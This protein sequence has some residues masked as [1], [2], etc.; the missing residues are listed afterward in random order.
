MGY[1][2]VALTGGMQMALSTEDMLAIQQ[3]YARYNHA[4][5]FARPAEWAACFT[6]DGVFSSA[7]TGES[8]GTEAL[9]AFATGFAARLKA[10]HWITNLLLEGDGD[11]ATGTCYLQLW[12]VAAAPASLLTTGTYVDQLAK[13]DGA[14]KFTR[15]EVKA[16]N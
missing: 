3:L 9:V 16:D 12:N 2:A 10:R 15:R 4:I 7:T 8:Q 13:M 6:A 5:D 11:R 14:W 1:A